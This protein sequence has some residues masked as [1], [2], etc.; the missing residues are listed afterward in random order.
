MNNIETTLLLT[1]I[2]IEIPERAKWVSIDSDGEICFWK[3]KPKNVNGVWYVD[4]NV[5]DDITP[6]YIMAV[7]DEYITMEVLDNNVHVYRLTDLFALMNGEDKNEND[8]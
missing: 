8:D 2:S 1:L 5:W 3:L 4:S 6:N 7:N